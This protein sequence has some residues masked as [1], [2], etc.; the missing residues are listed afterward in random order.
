[1][2]KRNYVKPVLSGEEFVPQNYI[3]ACGDSGTIYYFE[4]TANGGNLYYYKDGDG[5]IDGKY[6]GSGSAKLLGSYNPC[7]SKHEADSTNPFYDGFIDY[8]KN[9]KCDSGEEVIVWRGP[10]GYNGHATANLDMDTWETA[11]S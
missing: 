11:K 5:T 6:E 3:A 8:N 4:C 9:K 1:M 7:G 10:W 2:E